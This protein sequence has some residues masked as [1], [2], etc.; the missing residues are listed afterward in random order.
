MDQSGHLFHLFFKNK[1]NGYIQSFVRVLLC[2]SPG[3][4]AIERL[5]LASEAPSGKK[6]TWSPGAISATS[7][8]SRGP[9][10]QGLWEMGTRSTQLL[11]GQVPVC[12]RNP[13]AA[14]LGHS[15]LLLSTHP[16]SL[17]QTLPASAQLIQ[18]LCLERQS[19][20][21]VQNSP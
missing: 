13:Q 3:E 16:A 6:G 15:K 2:N 1:Q 11:R 14:L 9:P 5:P 20:Y 12:P 7:S 19:M 17:P 21:S 18:A 4:R 10:G 8:P